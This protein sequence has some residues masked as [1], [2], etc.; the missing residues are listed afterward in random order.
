MDDAPTRHAL[1]LQYVYVFV[2]FRIREKFN[3]NKYNNINQNRDLTYLR[4]PALI[5][6]L[7]VFDRLRC[8]FLRLCILGFRVPPLLMIL[9]LNIT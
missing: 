9:L 2:E 8:V 3:K 6:F 1:T 4:F 7:I 5:F